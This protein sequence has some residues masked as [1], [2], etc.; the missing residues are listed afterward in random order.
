[1]TQGEK[2]QREFGSAHNQTRNEDED[3]VAEGH[4]AA[5]EVFFLSEE[6]GKKSR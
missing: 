4:L 2:L 5:H 1:M 6:S 3:D